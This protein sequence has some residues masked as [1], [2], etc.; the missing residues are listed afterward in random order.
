MFYQT[1]GFSA[2]FTVEFWIAAV[3]YKNSLMQLAMTSVEEAFEQLGWQYQS[4]LKVKVL[5]GGEGEGV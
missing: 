5:V 3:R 2:D 4:S 1:Y